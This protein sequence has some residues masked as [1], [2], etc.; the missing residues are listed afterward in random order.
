MHLATASDTQFINEVFNHP[1][2]RPHVWDEPGEIDCTNAALMMWTVV[3]PGCG[4]M[5][6]ESMGGGNY[7]ALV[8]FLPGC[9]GLEAVNSMRRGI[10]KLFTETDC[11]R[12]YGCVAPSNRRA[13][14]NLIAQGFKEVGQTGNMVTGHIDYMDLLSIESFKD[15]A[16]GGWAGK[17]LYWWNIKAKLERCGE[18]IPLHPHLPIFSYQGNTIDLSETSQG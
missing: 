5:M 9:W 18:I 14:R 13:C 17:A 1:M 6:A 4:V 11:T 7:L 12:L 8:G 16:K 15:T 10:Y 2:V 3:E